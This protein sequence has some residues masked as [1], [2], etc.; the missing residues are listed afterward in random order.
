MKGVVCM[1]GFINKALNA[2]KKY[3]P[4]DFSILKICL[5]SIGVLCGVYFSQF[6]SRYI[7]IVWGIFIISYIW[8]MYKTF[9]KYRK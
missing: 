6:F 1:K 4:V 5:F 9:I 8:I 3:N 2:A 7:S